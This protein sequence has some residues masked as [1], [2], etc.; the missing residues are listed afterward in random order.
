[1]TKHVAL[2]REVCDFST[3][4]PQQRVETRLH[5]IQI[6]RQRIPNPTFLHQYETRTVHQAPALIQPTF[7]PCYR[8][9]EMQIVVFDNFNIRV[10]QNLQNGL[11]RLGPCY[12]AVSCEVVED[13]YQH[14]FASY[15]A[16]ATKPVRYL[17][18]LFTKRVGN[19]DQCHPIPCV[20]KDTT[21]PQSTLG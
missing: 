9:L 7:V 16:T 11:H 12:L 15:Y 13:L 19:M 6:M 8:S 3:I 20:S 18:S 2:T 4:P 21:Q 10:I 5:K 17:L 14:Q 1:M